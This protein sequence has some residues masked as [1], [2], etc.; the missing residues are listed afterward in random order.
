MIT[1]CYKIG[2]A[3]FMLAVVSF[4]GCSQEVSGDQTSGEQI[5]PTETQTQEAS[6]E[7]PQIAG[8]FFGVPVPMGNYY[9]AKRVVATFD[10]RWR[11]IPQ[12]QE[13]LE[14]M[15]WQELLLSYEAFRRD[16]TP[17][18]SKVDEEIDKILKAEKVEFNWRQ[19]KEEFERWSKDKLGVSPEVFR[20]QVVHL[21]TLEMLRQEV[22]DSIKPEVTEEEAYQKFLDEYNTLFVELVEFEDIEAAKKFYQEVTQPLPPD[23]LD[24]LIWGD[25]I[26]SYEAV[27]RGIEVEDKE[28]DARIQD[29]LRSREVRFNWQTNKEEYLNWIQE[30]IGVSEEIFRKR[31]MHF[32][33]IEK[34]MQAIAQNEQPQVDSQYE[35]YLKEQGTINTAYKNFFSVYPPLDGDVLRFSSL[36]EAE[37]FYNKLGREP[38]PW[39]EKKRKEPKL[40]K[41]PGFVAL[42]FLI[43]MWGF[44]RED[45]YAMMEKNVGDFYPPAPIYKGYAVF[46]ILKLRKADG[47]TFAQRKEYYFKRLETIKKQQGFKEWLEK[48]KK[49]AN[50]KVYLNQ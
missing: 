23:A 13:E 42:D 30:N 32:A 47:A 25:F 17:E 18:D 34:L 2:I 21:V 27:K 15:V 14:D 38:G 1:H 24:A 10:A 5:S 16:I 45:A 3:A 7:K 46:K 12:T 31:L 8:E 50:I 35:Q 22:L 44:K 37:E 29:F 11:G 26:L 40:F 33:K 4:F 49:E 19:D 20:N 43:H 41:R 48:L 39:E 9:F 36:K 28:V 6:L